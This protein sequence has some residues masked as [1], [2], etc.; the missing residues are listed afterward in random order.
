MLNELALTCSSDGSYVWDFR[1]GTVVLSLRQNNSSKHAVDLVPYSGHAGRVGLVMCAQS[2]RAIINVYSWQKEQVH[3]KILCPEKLTSLEISNR[4]A[5]CA[6]GTENGK[7][8][9]WELFS[10]RLCAVFDAHYKKVNVLRFTSDDT[11]LISGSED[12]GVNVWLMAS[13]VDELTDDVPSPYYAWSEHSLPITDIVCG[14]GSFL[15]ARV[16]TSSV[17]HTCKLWNLS[18]G[19]LLTTFVFPTIITC[20]AMDP[21]E[22]MFFAGGGDNTIYQVNL[23]RKGEERDI[24]D[25]GLVFRGHNAPL[26][27]LSL[28]FDSSLLVSGSEDGCVNIWDTSSRQLVKRLAQHK[29]PI[30]NVQTFLKPPDLFKLSP[31][32][33]N[34][35][36]QP[37][38]PFKKTKNIAQKDDD[39]YGAIVV[40]DGADDYDKILDECHGR[41]VK[42]REHLNLVQVENITTQL[43]MSDTTAALESKVNELQSELSRI[44]GH[45]QR[46]KSL[47]NEMYQ[48]LVD[49]FMQS[50]NK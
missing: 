2:D 22:R 12:A 16:L 5:Y 27:T 1:A 37:I 28:S 41:A 20:L 29:G 7:I 46:V 26:S 21:A 30:T 32:P 33:T 47:H 31:Y 23:Y 19:T 44:H 11:V 25:G 8:Y 38:Q 34:T 6:G 39:D 24:G 15:T 49:E 43:Q 18:S 45:Y 9:L 36:I 40:I 3:M 17:D 48:N 14:I 35:V 10:G 50:R 4:G 42:S 13:L